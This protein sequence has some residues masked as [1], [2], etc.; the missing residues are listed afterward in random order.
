MYN[1][2]LVITNFK[3]GLGVRAQKVTEKLKLSLLKFVLI[4]FDC[5]TNG[6]PSLLSVSVIYAYI[7][8]G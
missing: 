3:T 8:H 6:R 4:V 1:Y 7:Y 5:K 2:S